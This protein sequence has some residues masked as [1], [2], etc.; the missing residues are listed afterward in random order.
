MITPKEQVV[1]PGQY[2]KFQCLVTGT[3]DY[4]VT[5]T[6]ENGSLLPP[7]MIVYGPI[8]RIKSATLSDTNAY[9]C[10]VQSTMGVSQSVARLVVEGKLRV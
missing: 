1:K 5:W 4:T 9:V 3:G 10:H 7:H 6:L 2:V 8:I